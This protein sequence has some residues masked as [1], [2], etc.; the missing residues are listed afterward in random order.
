MAIQ[1]NDY[2]EISNNE[3]GYRGQITTYKPNAKLSKE[4]EI[5]RNGLFIAAS[6]TYG[7]SYIEPMIRALYG[8]VKPENSDYDALD[9]KTN[10][11]F[12]I[13]SAKV[14]K[15]KIKKKQ[16]T[17]FDKI[18]SE[19]EE[20]PLFRIV[21]FED[22]KTEKYDANIQNVKRDH[23][24]SLIYILLFNEG[25]EIFRIKTDK[26]D[27]NHISNW[28]DKHG[29]YDELGKSGQFN[30]KSGMIEYHEKTHF[31]RF[32]SYDELANIAKGV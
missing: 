9:T 10:E 3:V 19:V 23:F 21:N 20:D 26:I 30:I 16:K 13:K 32:V 27:K 31:D 7:E 28:S 1:L 25:I 11:K 8:Y 15:T 29:R 5:L 17:L 18:S 4:A 22:R 14:L 12:E 6:R 2:I 24:D